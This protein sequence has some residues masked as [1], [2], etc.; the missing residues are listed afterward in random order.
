MLPLSEGRVS[1]AWEPPSIMM[2]FSPRHA[3]E[4][5]TILPLLLCLFSLIF[6]KS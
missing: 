4:H 2:H 5:L 6:V 3:V 1:E